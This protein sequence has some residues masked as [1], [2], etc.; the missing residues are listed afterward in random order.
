MGTKFGELKNFLYLCPQYKLKQLYY[1]EEIIHSIRSLNRK[2][3]VNFKDSA[4]VNYQFKYLTMNEN[5]LVYK[6]KKKKDKEKEKENEIIDISGNE[7][8][9]CR[10]DSRISFNREEERFAPLIIHKQFTDQQQFMGHKA[11]LDEPA[12]SGKLLEMWILR[13]NP[14]PTE[15]T[16][17]F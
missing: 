6:K 9:K 10:K 13:T 1:V 12:A 15:S 7:S 17:V 4:L 2:I 11:L 14:R 8:Y 16:P 3:L 5:E